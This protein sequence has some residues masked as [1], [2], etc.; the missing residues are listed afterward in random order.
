M[1]LSAKVEG[2]VKDAHGNVILGKT[3]MED[4]HAGRGPYVTVAMDKTSDWQG[5]YLISSKYPGVVFRVMDN[6]GYGNNKTGR[7]WIDIAWTDPERAKAGTQRNLDFQV[8]SAT[9]A[10]E[11]AEQRRRVTG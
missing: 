2:G 4:F 8:V 9:E 1:G 7:N 10:R 6:G 11:I 3:T 5:K